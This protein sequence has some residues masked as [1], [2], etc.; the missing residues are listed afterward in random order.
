MSFKRHALMLGTALTLAGCAT[1]AN[2][3]NQMV[4]L[5]VRGS[6]S[7]YCV[8]ENGDYKNAVGFHGTGTVTLERSR[9][10]LNVQCWGDAGRYKKFEMTPSLAKETAYDVGTGIL[11][12]VAYDMFGGGMWTWDSPLYIDFR[13]VH[14]DPETPQPAW[15][16]EAIEPIVKNT[17]DG[18]VLSESL[19]DPTL[20]GSNPR[21]PAEA[22]KFLSSIGAL[23]VEGN[24]PEQSLTQKPKPVLSEEDFAKPHPKKAHKAKKKAAKPADTK[25]MADTKEDTKPAATSEVKPAAETETTPPALPATTQEKPAETKPTVETSVVTPATT[26]TAT[27]ETKSD[28]PAATDAA[29]APVTEPATTATP[30]PVKTDAATPTP[31]PALAPPASLPPPSSGTAT[32]TTSSAATETESTQD[33]TPLIQ[34]PGLKGLN[35]DK[36][37]TLPPHLRVAP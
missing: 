26:E 23:P 27:P 36:P 20:G 12:G 15:P 37:A 6:D 7:A 11:P 4:D 2:T 9:K 31:A 13:E 5:Q 32:P 16:P 10:A 14:T 22:S 3:S 17:G 24:V 33:T 1:V 29:P 21:P 35:D 34:V 18:D 28:A 30:E 19:L 8:F 25:P